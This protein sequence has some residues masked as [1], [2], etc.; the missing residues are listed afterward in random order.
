MSNPIAID[1]AIPFTG[2]R[3]GF[4][5]HAQFVTFAGFPKDIAANPPHALVFGD[6]SGGQIPLVRV[7][8]GCRTGDTFGSA[9]CDCGS[10]LTDALRMMS[11][12][13]EKGHGG[14]LLYLP[15]HEGRGIGLNQ[16]IKAYDLMRRNLMMDTYTANERLGH[17]ADERD[18]TTAAQMIGTLG[19]TQFYLLSGNPAKAEHLSALGKEMGFDI[20]EQIPTSRHATAGNNRY[21]HDKERLGGHNFAG[22]RFMPTP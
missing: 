15:H 21:L 22:G 18:Y 17:D 12:L 19:I 8:S 5:Y 14:A 6:I 2:K 7:H 20:L 16:K 11:D 3:D 4:D 13:A 1:T 9:L 10:Q